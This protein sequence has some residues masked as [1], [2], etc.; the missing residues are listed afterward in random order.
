MDTPPPVTPASNSPSGPSEKQ[1]KVILHLSA[2]VG[3][4]APAIGNIIAPLVIWL[5]KKDELPGIDAEGR[6]VLN[7]QISYAIYMVLAG[8]SMFACIGVLLFPAV[9][10]VWLVFTII[11]A[12]KASNGEDYKF[13]MTIKM[14]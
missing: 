10:I 7:F 14:L 13:P 3:L 12:V 9:M 11:G 4:P 5:V 2:L 6:K 8:L 1:W